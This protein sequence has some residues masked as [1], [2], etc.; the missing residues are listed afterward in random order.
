MGLRAGRLVV[1]AGL[2]AMSALLINPAGWVTVHA[3]QT[4]DVTS[5]GADPTGVKDST[6]PVQSAINDAQ[7]AGPSNIIRRSCA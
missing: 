2:C 3:Q 7:A 6:L 5:Y 1:G 4:F